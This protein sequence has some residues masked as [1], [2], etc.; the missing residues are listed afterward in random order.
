MKSRVPKL[1][2][3]RC[4]CLNST[5]FAVHFHLNSFPI[6]VIFSALHLND[7]RASKSLS[8]LS[9]VL[10]VNTAQRRPS[11]VNVGQCLPST[12]NVGDSEKATLRSQTQLRN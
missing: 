1:Y 5:V 3:G 2:L 9:S 6:A 4:L 12:G 11:T 7:I 10:T 8:E